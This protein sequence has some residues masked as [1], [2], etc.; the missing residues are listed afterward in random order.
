MTDI[1]SVKCRAGMLLAVKLIRAISTDIIT[2]Q[3]CALLIQSGLSAESCRNHFT[4][5][6]TVVAVDLCG[7][8]FIQVLF[9]NFAGFCRQCNVLW[10]HFIYQP[11]FVFCAIL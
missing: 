3:S 5:C 2:L 4:W 11:K 9:I 7:S 8:R 1:K 6:F 10:V